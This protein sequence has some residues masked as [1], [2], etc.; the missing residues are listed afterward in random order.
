MTTLELIWNDG[1][2]YHFLRTYNVTVVDDDDYD[3]Y[4]PTPTRTPR[5]TATP[6]PT[7]TPTTG[8]TPTPTATATSGPTAT[9]TPTPT[10][11][12]AEELDTAI[13]MIGELHDA[14]TADQSY[15]T[16]QTNLLNCLST[17]TSTRAGKPFSFSSFDAMLD[18]YT[19]D[20]R[21]KIAQDCSSQESAMFSTMQSVYGTELAD[22]KRNNAD[23]RALLETAYGQAFED[24]VG[25]PDF[26]K[27]YATLMAQE[28]SGAS[29]STS[30]AL[31]P[32]NPTPV[33][34]GVNCLPPGATASTLEEKVD[35]LN[36]LVVDTPLQ[37]WVT[38]SAKTKEGNDLA[39]ASD[40]RYDF[41]GYGDWRCS[42]VY[43]LGLE[44]PFV[45]G[46]L[47][48]DVAYSS[49]QEFA[50]TQTNTALDDFERDSTW[51]PRNKYLADLILKADF[52]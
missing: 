46:C 32:I 50:G 1:T 33:P 14:T 43:I 36:C 28:V 19:T 40:N 6:T 7:A 47:R 52:M 24:D 41:L 20:V 10:P 34:L 23:Y 16:A 18:N 21:A 45:P 44:P 30:N 17:D 5:Y 51:H 13:R 9:H 39:G 35:A 42:I 37:F 22:L 49:L 48:H 15:R 31:A 3:G 27:L 29:S 38:Q 2:R 4:T 11:T 25:N 8:P 12:V 26:I